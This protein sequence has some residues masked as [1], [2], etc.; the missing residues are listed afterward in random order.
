[1]KN[2]VKKVVLLIVVLVGFVLPSFAD[3]KAK[4]EI[5]TAC[6]YFKFACGAGTTGAGGSGH[7]GKD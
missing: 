2:H 3:D 5:S 1:M 4:K 7:G 6:K